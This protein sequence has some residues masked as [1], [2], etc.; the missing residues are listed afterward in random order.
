M[1]VIRS[2]VVVVVVVVAWLLLL[3]IIATCNRSGANVL[4]LDELDSIFR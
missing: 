3:L 2:V 1:T 4:F